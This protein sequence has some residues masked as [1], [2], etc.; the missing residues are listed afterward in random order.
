MNNN[1]TLKKRPWFATLFCAFF[2]LV[3]FMIVAYVYSL[4]SGQYTTTWQP[5]YDDDVKL[6]RTKSR[7]TI[8]SIL[9]TF[10]AA[11]QAIMKTVLHAA[12]TPLLL[13]YGFFMNAVIGYMGDQGFGKDDGFSLPK[14]ID[15]MEGQ[16]AMSGF[17]ASL[18]YV[19]GSLATY[20]FWR[21]IVT[22]FLDM[23]ISM[24]L[25]SIIVSVTEGVI[26]DLK[27]SVPFIWSPLQPVLNTLVANYDNILQSFVG[28]VTFL[29]YTNDTRFTWAYP[30]SDIDSSKLISSGTIKLA[31]CI[32]GI[33][34]LIANIGADFNI[35]N[36]V[37]INPGTA[38]SDTL[39]RKLYF[40][41]IIIFLLTAGSMDET[42]LNGNIVPIFNF[43]NYN[44][45]R[46]QI[47]PITNYKNDQFWGIDK[48]KNR[49][50]NNLID[51][52]NCKFG[53]FKMCGTD[54]ITGNLQLNDDNKIKLIKEYRQ[55]KEECDPEKLNEGIV[56]TPSSIFDKYTNK[57]VF[58]IA[59]VASIVFFSLIVLIII[60][61]YK[62]VGSTFVRY[63]YG[64]LLVILIGLFG[65]SGLVTMNKREK[66]YCSEKYEDKTTD[67]FATTTPANNTT[68]TA[69][70]S[71]KGEGT[72]STQD[73]CNKY[74]KDNNKSF[75]KS[76]CEDDS[77]APLGCYIYS[78]DNNVYFN[79][80]KT[81][82][83][84]A[85]KKCISFSNDEP[86]VASTEENSEKPKADEQYIKK[87]VE[88]FLIDY[89][90]ELKREY[91]ITIENLNDYTTID[92][93]R[94]EL[95]KKLNTFTLAEFKTDQ[96]NVYTDKII[97]TE[98]GTNKKLLGDF[99][100]NNNSDKKDKT[101]LFDLFNRYTD[102]CLVI[103]NE[104]VSDCETLRN[105]V[106]GDLIASFIEKNI[107]DINHYLIN[108]ITGTITTEDIKNTP[109]Y[110]EL[111][112]II[113]KD[114]EIQDNINILNEKGKLKSILEK[115]ENYELLEPLIEITNKEKML[116]ILDKIELRYN[117]NLGQLVKNI[118]MGVFMKPL[119]MIDTKYDILNKSNLGF[120]ILCFYCF[121]GYIVPF[122]PFM[123]GKEEKQYAAIW[124]VLLMT[125][126]I[127]G[128]L[129]LLFIISSRAPETEKIKK[130]ELEIIYK[131]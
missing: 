13:L 97:G 60:L 7:G 126:L 46:F 85:T 4:F 68:T 90:R 38:L 77:C 118:E 6:K 131:S 125:A 43:M 44:P 93:Y 10:G 51:N 121:I 18:K 22:V 12:E 49:D 2:L 69:T 78:G 59:L 123:Y 56:D 101:N 29:A 116:E 75:N 23:F 67:G 28:F 19:F 16:N 86:V 114:T 39:D 94:D 37:K 130:K 27:Y 119:N 73:Q 70:I 127:V 14:I 66:L 108:K 32:S 63:L 107:D 33:V 30:G 103:N 104:M 122:F 82:D 26:N 54:N 76:T 35:V 115:D 55:L 1:N 87:L 98:P 5:N 95:S 48:L 36:G 120:V 106:L 65:C 58:V 3:P 15:K 11:K 17:G 47:S 109:L 91:N 88:K 42:T 64:L 84:S 128:L 53:Q 45:S 99:L 62:N 20:E 105:L 96:S 129:V 9:L 81:G 111:N 40:V 80:N 74:A 34:Y 57:S 112:K 79:E 8:I 71:E 124:K 110:A 52:P 21:Y 83:C 92:G 89:D 117:K 41:L 24:P 25:Q 72:L 31:T 50:I 61:G 113:T 100:K 102:S